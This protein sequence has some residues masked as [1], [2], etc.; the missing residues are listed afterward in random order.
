MYTFLFFF[1]IFMFFMRAPKIIIKGK[2][3]N[4]AFNN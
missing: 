2:K 3:T 4:Y 1:Y